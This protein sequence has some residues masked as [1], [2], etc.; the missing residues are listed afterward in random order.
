[1]ADINHYRQLIQDLLLEYS[2]IR[3]NNEEVEAPG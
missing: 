3:A 1:M 2:K